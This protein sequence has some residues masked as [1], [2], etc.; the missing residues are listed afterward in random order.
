MKTSIIALLIV[1]LVAA[2]WGI[3]AARPS[4]SGSQSSSKVLPISLHRHIGSQ[5]PCPQCKNKTSVRIVQTNAE[6]GRGLLHDGEEVEFI[7]DQRYGL[8]QNAPTRICKRCKFSWHDGSKLVTIS[9]EDIPTK[10]PSPLASYDN[11][12]AQ[13]PQVYE[14][15]PKL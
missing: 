12:G 10:D 8:T 4:D 6:S 13:R 15:S 1:L 3:F 14:S 2:L 11:D 9:K 7:N 5:V